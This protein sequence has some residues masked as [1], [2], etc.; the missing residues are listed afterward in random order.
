M[1]PEPGKR[2]LHHLV[3]R[4]PRRLRGS[5]RPI[6]RRADQQN[7]PRGRRARPP[8]VDHPDWRPGRGQPAT[9]TAARPAER[10]TRRARPTPQ[11]PGPDPGRQGLLP[12]R[13]P[14]R[15]A[16]TRDQ[17]HQ[18]RTHGPDRSPRGEGLGRWATTRLRPDPLR[19]TQR[20]RALLQPAQTV[21]QPSHPLRQA[22]YLHHPEL[23]EEAFGQQA[24]ALLRQLDT[25]CANAEQLATATAERFAQHPDAAIIT[26]LPGLAEL[27][28]ARVL[29]EIGDDRARFAD[30]RG[31]KA[32]AGSAPV[33]R[34]AARPPRSC[35]GGSR[36]SAW[37]PSA[38][39]GRSPR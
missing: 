38:T 10:R 14:S 29:A 26:S 20:G 15:V 19:R 7:P 4:R 37:P 21:P 23:V 1:P 32:Y 28:G 18:P 5:P 31:L 12:P 2:G 17:V 36:T 35:T 6:P 25:A 24:L 9:A 27:T 8:D 11:T 16:A 13:H 34:A 22:D 33:T 39:S 30:A 3:G